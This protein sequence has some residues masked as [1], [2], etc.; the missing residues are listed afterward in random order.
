VTAIRLT[1]KNV[2]TAAT[3]TALYAVLG[4][5]PFSPIIGIPGKAITAAAMIAPILGIL[6]GPYVGTL[7]ALMGGVLGLF[8]G[9]LSPPSVYAGAAT[10]LCSG[11]IY[12]GKRLI[13]VVLYV[14]L[15][16][17]LAFYPSIGPAWL[18]PTYTWF[19]IVGLTILISPAQVSA[20][21]SFESENTSRLFFAFSMTSLVSTVAGQIAGTLVFETYQLPE[22]TY[23][24]T[25]IG[26]AF[27]Y[28]VERTIIALGS[29]LIGTALF[30]ALKPSFSPILFHLTRSEK[31]P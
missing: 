30:K 23:L 17:A 21:N 2:A 28:P 11:T 1:A 31:H 27:W 16:L 8:L 19:Q 14:F 18:F 26:T 4:F 5:V 9:S 20:V 22:A 3:F 24:G 6:L 12:G 7:S 13:A 29:A 25:W 10:A 15:F